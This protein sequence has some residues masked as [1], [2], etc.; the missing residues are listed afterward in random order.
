MDLFNQIEFF[1]K[2]YPNFVIYEYILLNP[3][4]DIN[5]SYDLILHYLNIGIKNKYLMSIKHFYQLYP[6]FNLIFY[7]TFY[8]NLYFDN[9]IQYLGHY[10]HHGINDNKY[11][12]FQNFLSIYCRKNIK[13]IDIDFINIFYSSNFNIIENN[14]IEF[15]YFFKNL[16]E[17][18]ID[19]II[20]KNHFYE[21]FSD[22]SLRIF[23][24][25]NN[26]PNEIIPNE[27]NILKYWFENKN[28][29][30][31]IDNPKKF[32]LNN[33]EF[34][35]ELYLF[36]YNYEELNE[37]NILYWSKNKDNLIYSINTFKKHIVDFQYILFIKNIAFSKNMSNDDIINFYI[38]NIKKLSNIIY[39]EKIFNLK[40]PD[41]NIKDYIQFH[42]IKNTSPLSIY[43]NYHSTKDKDNIII[44]INNFYTKYNNFNIDVYKYYLNNK[45]IKFNT[46]NEYIYYLVSNND[47]YNYENAYKKF[48]INLYKKYGM[49][50]IDDIYIKYPDFDINL[51]IL[52]N[53]LNNYNK[54]DVIIHFLQIGLIQNLPYK[55]DNIN[56]DNIG[57]NLNIY[58]NLNKDIKNLTDYDLFF[59]WFNKGKFQNRI[60]SIKT[61]FIKYPDLINILENNEESIIYW[62]NIGIYKN[63][64]NEYIGRSEVNDIYE[65]LID[66]D[67]MTEKNKLK[68]GISL[69]IRAKNEELNI[70][71]C[72]E[73]VVDLVDEII[74]VDNNS[75]DSTYSIVKKYKEKYNNIKLYKYNIN[76]SKV[77]KEH[78]DA[79]NN[80]DPNTLGN[81]YNWC[82]SKSNYNNV[83]KWDADFICIRNNFIQLVNYYKL[84]NRTDK[85]AIWFTGLTLFENNFKY[86]LNYNSYYNEFRIFSY[87]NNFCWYDGNICEYVDPYINSCISEK[88]YYYSF[89]IF[90]ELKRTSIDE[91]QERSNMIDSRDINDFN[92]LNNLKNNSYNNLLPLP[93]DSI[94]KPKNIIIYTPSLSFGGG[95]QF[96]IQIYKFYKSIGNNIVIIPL[97]KNNYD[98]KKFN[99]IL[100]IDIIDYDLFNVNFIQ[101]FNPDFIIMNSDIPFNLEKIEFISTITKIYFVTHSDVAYSNFFIQKYSDFLYKIITVNNYTIN[102]LSYLLNI[103][104]DKFIH[105]L[106]YTHLFDNFNID[107]NKIIN[108]KFGVISR[109][110]EDK[111]IP[112]LIISLKNIFNKYPD[113]KC[114]LIGSYT[115]Y[116]DNYL[117]YLSKSYGLDKNIIFEGYQHDVSKYYQILDFIILPSVSEGCSY[118]IIEAMKCGLP[119]IVSNVGG[120]NELVINNK[121]GYIYDYTDIKDYEKN[122]IFITNYNKHLSLIG[123]I[124]KEELNNNLLLN[125]TF[126]NI[127]AILPFSLK[128]ILHNEKDNYTIHSNNCCY[129]EFIKNKI[130]LFNKNI[131]SIEN[132]ILNM[133]DKIKTNKNDFD[134]ISNNNINFI[135]N[136]YNQYKYHIQLLDLL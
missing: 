120:N 20:S 45:N 68:N 39:S 127:E 49:L 43:N 94:Y 95:N 129:C 58:R 134:N 40:Y 37:D 118:N 11:Y 74:F 128:C 121:N 104:N 92:I 30:Y 126:E 88:K 61:F 109:F 105:L 107:K 87:K 7:K 93:D 97:T 113:Y 27:I 102:K 18:N 119:V 2:K 10:Y 19:I 51:Y 22:F 31:F 33:P 1:Y 4:E 53:N 65:V 23:L 115:E 80:K 99:E 66:L 124:I 85:Y 59:H 116:Y 57:I 125:N 12:S 64:Q 25:F 56:E 79:I 55:I 13:D 101:Q 6:N 16:F 117:K 67:N 42:K 3:I 9:D 130:D 111:N 91:F 50:S 54:D 98:N 89:P 8:N 35:E 73:S 62:M 108:K 96:I 70:K 106:N 114:Y 24:E 34:I 48:S 86:Y 76:V 71:D 36:I 78:K 81:F 122:T 52:L 21:Y 72:I 123:Y 132:S 28:I 77:G 63:N 46:D 131:Y 112:M 38:K 14:N 32:L 29:I 82:L 41:F 84:K 44:S 17:N 83:F 135:K 75:T 100:E 26:I 60:Y 90:F 136:N 15:I 103:N 47:F 69:I 5:E 110:S 133:I